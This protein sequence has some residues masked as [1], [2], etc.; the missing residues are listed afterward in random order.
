MARRL[1]QGR[2]LTIGQFNNQTVASEE[3]GAAHGRLGV[4][5]R[6]LTPDERQQAG[7]EAGVMVSEASG[8]AAA[9]GIEPGDIILGVNNTPVK[10]VQQLRSLVV[11]T[12]DFENLVL[13]GILSLLL[14]A[15]AFLLDIDAL[16]EERLPVSVLSV[17]G[18]VLSTVAIADSRYST[19][20]P[21]LV[22]AK[23]TT[24]SPD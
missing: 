9:A 20:S 22:N 12:I 17:G 15:G 21:R 8:V 14:F 2:R 13:H 23:Q 6:P 24:T 1:D 7:V 4:A 16:V 19:C 5:V 3:A 10:S 18:T 11:G